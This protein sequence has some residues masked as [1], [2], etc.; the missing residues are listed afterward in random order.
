MAYFYHVSYNSNIVVLSEEEIRIHDVVLTLLC[1]I[2]CWD[3]WLGYN[4]GSILNKNSFGFGLHH[5]V[6]FLHFVFFLFSHDLVES[7]IIS[8]SVP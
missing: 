6:S 2:E 7:S 8:V 5:A 4:S 3:C 1:N